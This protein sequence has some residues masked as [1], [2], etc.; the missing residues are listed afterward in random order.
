VTLNPVTGVLNLS[1]ATRAGIYRFTIKAANLG[2]A[3]TQ[4][5]VLTLVS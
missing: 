3:V 1:P 2:G 5:F 4:D